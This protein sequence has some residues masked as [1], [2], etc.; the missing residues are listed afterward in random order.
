[1]TSVLALV[2]GPTEVMHCAFVLERLN[3][4]I[5]DAR[6]VLYGAKISMPETLRVETLQL[7]NLFYDWSSMTDFCDACD[8][9]QLY[10]ATAQ[11]RAVRD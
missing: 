2:C 11:R 6:L 7:A 4:E 10:Q 9:L 8:A 5:E 3:L 1:M